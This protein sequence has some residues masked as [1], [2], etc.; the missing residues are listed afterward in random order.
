MKAIIYSR[1]SSP[2]ERQNTER[3]ILDLTKYAEISNMEIK[4][5]FSEKI[6]GT[7]I[8]TERNILIECLEYAKSEEIEIVLFSELSRLGRNILQVQEIIKWFA[9]NKINAY[10]QKEQLTLLNDEGEVAPTTTILIACL[11]MVAQIERDNIKFRLNSGR[12][13]AKGKGIKMGRKNGSTE[14]I[15]VKKE[16]YPISINLLK[17]NYKMVDIVAIATSK[18]EK[19]SLPTVKRLKKLVS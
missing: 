1:V 5:V 3:Q 11:A 18:G 6:S 9:D 2:S 14:T 13:R 8:N 7:T 4:K 10:F 15:E 19:I 12:Q 17:K 16:K